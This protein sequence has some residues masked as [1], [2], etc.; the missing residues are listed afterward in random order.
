VID[1]VMVHREPGRGMI[2][3]GLTLPPMTCFEEAAAAFREK[4]G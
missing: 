4:Y 1:I 3:F 2:G